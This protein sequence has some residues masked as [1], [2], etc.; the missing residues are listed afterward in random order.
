LKV[1]RYAKLPLYAENGIIELWIVNLK[2]GQIE[3]YREPSGKAFHKMSIH[4][5][6]ETVSPL[7]FPTIKLSVAEILGSPIA[8]PTKRS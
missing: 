1:D 7:K 6:T 8:R 5:K 3:I 2:I 4:D